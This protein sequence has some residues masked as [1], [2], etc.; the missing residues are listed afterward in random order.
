MH[1]HKSDV[2]IYI[3][4]M[5]TLTPG[6]GL[7]LS[8]YAG[9]PPHTWVKFGPNSILLGQILAK[10]HTLGS[11][12]GKNPYLGSDFDKSSYFIIRI[13]LICKYCII[14]LFQVLAL[15]LTFNFFHTSGSRF[16]DFPYFWVSI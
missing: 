3:T 11:D 15:K 13:R 2:H 14:F 8:G 4:V 10:F 5:C 6:G 9:M 16:K 7:P 12:F 1:L